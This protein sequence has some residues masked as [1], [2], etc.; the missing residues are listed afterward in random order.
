MEPSETCSDLCQGSQKG[1]GIKVKWAGTTP[2]FSEPK[3]DRGKS[4]QLHYL[5]QSQVL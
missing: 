5:F 4:S 2:E 1:A 3:E